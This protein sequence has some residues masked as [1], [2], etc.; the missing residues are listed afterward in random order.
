MN[1]I[2]LQ[3]IDET[4]LKVIKKS[5][6]SLSKDE[7]VEKVR[8]RLSKDHDTNI[9]FDAEDFFIIDNVI[10][11]YINSSDLI[12]IGNGYKYIKNTSLH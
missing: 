2:Y 5:K 11:D 4:V 12:E 3:N 6:K 7:I 9:I 1:N 10:N 8:I